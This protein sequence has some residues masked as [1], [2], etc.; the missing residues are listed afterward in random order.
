MWKGNGSVSQYEYRFME[1]SRFS[2]S[3]V[4]DQ[5]ER[6][7]NFLEGLRFK[8]RHMVSVTQWLVFGDLVEA[9]KRVE[10]SLADQ[11]VRQE[12]RQ[13]RSSSQSEQAEN[14]SKVQK[15]WG[16]QSSGNVR[17]GASQQTRTTPVAS[18]VQGS[19]YQSYRL[20]QFQVCGKSH[21]GECKQGSSGCYRCGE[22]GHIK[23]DC[24]Q[25]SLSEAMTPMTAPDMPPGEILRSMFLL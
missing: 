8:I 2:P 25:Q 10:S 13:K 1:L 7:Q 9:A 18:D 17:G 23:K 21:A 19:Y 20:P 6:C 16:P 11:R 3:L 12:Q 5:E 22:V 24:P 4:A 14:P 15:L